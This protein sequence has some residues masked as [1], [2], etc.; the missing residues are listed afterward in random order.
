MRIV[1]LHQQLLLT[2]SFITFSV[3]LSAAYDW[4]RGGHLSG[5]TMIFRGIWGLLMLSECVLG[6]IIIAWDIRVLNNAL[7]LVYG[8][9]ALMIV[10]TVQWVLPRLFAAQHHA[11]SL[12]IAMIFVA[13]VLHRLATTGN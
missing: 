3:M 6:I 11:R 2:I 9:V 12:T 8:L 10:A 13:I 5:R 4:W 7:H 1:L